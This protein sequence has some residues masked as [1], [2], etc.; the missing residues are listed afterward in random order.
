MS[1]TIRYLLNKYNKENTPKKIKIKNIGNVIREKIEELKSIS[2][3]KLLYV[4]S[5]LPLD[6]LSPYLLKYKEFI[7]IPVLT[8]ELIYDFWKDIVMDLY[9]GK[10]VCR[11]FDY[12][13]ALFEY[14][15][16]KH[17][18]ILKICID[19]CF[20]FYMRKCMNNPEI[21][22]YI[23]KLMDVKKIKKKIN[24]SYI[25]HY[26]FFGSIIYMV[27]KIKSLK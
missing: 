23:S 1:A 22:S 3:V 10:K 18:S 15:K 26:N 4:L 24:V 27:K 9:P 12:M 13:K 21:L 7:L 17:F 19:G 20:I 2:I 14:S 25:K 6:F 5:K 8:E 11:F 16:K